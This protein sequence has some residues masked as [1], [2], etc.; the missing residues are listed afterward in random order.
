[1]AMSDWD[2]SYKIY[3]LGA[4]TEDEYTTWRIWEDGN[5]AQRFYDN[6]DNKAVKEKVDGLIDQYNGGT[7]PQV[8]PTQGNTVPE[9]TGEPKKPPTDLPE[10]NNTTGEKGSDVT[11]STAALTKFSENI[12]TY[13]THIDRALTAVKAVDIRPG[14]FGAAA[15][16]TTSVQGTDN[17]AGLKGDTEK[18]LNSVNALI[19]DLQ[20]DIGNLILD[21][22][23]TEERNGM[24]AQGLNQAFNETFSNFTVI[25][26][27]GNV[28]N[29]TGNQGEG[30]GNGN[31][32]K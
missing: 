13:R 20:A 27:T 3:E 28:T 29:N 24:T 32:N 12:G 17:A 4:I 23:T 15:N 18:F 14:Y 22:D 10:V 7:L 5:A 25:Q 16:I 6:P 26:Q 1:M 2:A 21:Y 30:N 19:Y 31:N 11:V 8:N 9:Q